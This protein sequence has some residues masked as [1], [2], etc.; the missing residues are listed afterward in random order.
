M[1]FAKLI[2]RF[3]ICAFNKFRNALDRINASC[4][5]RGCLTDANLNLLSSVN[6]DSLDSLSDFPHD[7]SVELHQL[8]EDFN[9][10]KQVNN[11]LIDTLSA[12]STSSVS[13]VRQSSSTP[14]DDDDDSV[15]LLPLTSPDFQKAVNPLLQFCS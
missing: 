3:F 1:T 5:E 4:Y 14:L 12:L 11:S 9:H 7:D 10:L 8:R 6:V 15:S 13:S 2:S